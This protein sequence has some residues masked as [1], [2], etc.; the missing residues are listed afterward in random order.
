MADLQDL[1]NIYCQ[2]KK[3]PCNMDCQGS[4]KSVR[5]LGSHIFIETDDWHSHNTNTSY[6]LSDI[7][8]TID[9]QNDT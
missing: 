1:M 7:P 5:S 6:N 3:R 8:I 4:R 2:E 9:I